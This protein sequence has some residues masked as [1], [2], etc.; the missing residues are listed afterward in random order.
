MF[1]KVLRSILI[2]ATL[3][4]HAPLCRLHASC[5]VLRVTECTSAPV[6]VEC[7]CC[8]KTHVTPC[9]DDGTDQPQPINSDHKTRSCHC[10]CGLVAMGYVPLTLVVQVGLVQD[11]CTQ[12]N[13]SDCCH[14]QDGFE[15]AIDRPPRS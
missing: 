6:E 4:L 13:V 5:F 1:G 10:L 11:A 15:Q 12:L 3:H 8:K 14:K 2:L 7:E 9:H